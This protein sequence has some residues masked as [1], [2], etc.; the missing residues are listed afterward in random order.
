MSDR[1]TSGPAPG[2]GEYGPIPASAPSAASAE[3]RVPPAAATP[4]PAPVRSSA[5]SPA[6][7]GAGARPVPRWDRVVT[8]ALLA[9][10]AIN[11][12]TTIPQ[13]LHLPQTLDEVYAQQGWGDYTSDSLASAIGIAVNVL[14]VVL[15]LAA[16]GISVRRLRTARLTFWVPLVAGVTAVIVTMVLLSA[17]MLIDPALPA[18]I[19]T[20][21]SPAP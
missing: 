2:Y 5:A 18:F 21:T 14:S 10:A 16:V 8:I 9:L 7:G 3:S 1:P 4:E 13:M 20:Q 12:L 19:Q 17:A 11:V 15:L 6:G